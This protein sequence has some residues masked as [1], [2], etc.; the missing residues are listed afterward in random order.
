MVRRGSRVQVPKVAP[1]THMEN[2]SSYITREVERTRNRTR[3]AGLAA[4]AIGLHATLLLDA[5]EKVADASKL[6]TIIGIAAIVLPSVCDY[7]DYRAWLKSSGEEDD[8]GDDW[9]DDDPNPVAPDDPGGLA[10][11]WTKEVE[12]FANH[13]QPLSV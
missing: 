10:A 11:D 2:E 12:D 13:R 3:L 6:T 8:D 1:F 5:G 9:P 4:W 7:Q